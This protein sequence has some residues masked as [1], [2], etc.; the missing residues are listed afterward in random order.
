MTGDG[1]GDDSHHKTVGAT[2]E[3]RRQGLRIVSP[4]YHLQV[5]ERG[6]G[7]A[8]SDAPS[9]KVDGGCRH[10]SCVS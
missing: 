8:K 10:L 4:C 2:V 5:L 6:S 7:C 3:D 1:L 9:Y